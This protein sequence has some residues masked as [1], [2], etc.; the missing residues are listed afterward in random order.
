MR[1]RARVHRAWRIAH[2]SASEFPVGPRRLPKGTRS[3][4]IASARDG[5]L[6]AWTIRR[7]PPPMEF[8]SKLLAPAVLVAGALAALFAA[9][10]RSRHRPGIVLAGGALLAYLVLATP[11]GSS[12]LVAPLED[13]V[14]PARDC[15]PLRPDAIVVVLAG[16]MGG[17]A[18]RGLDTT[19]L[20][21]ASLRRT[22]AAARLAHEAPGLAFVL[23]GGIAVA[24][25]RAAAGDVRESDLMRA[26]MVELGVQPE[27]LVLERE[28]RNTWEN[29]TGS[30][31]LL[32]RGPWQGR[33]TY[34]VTSA[35]HMPRAA[36]TFRKAGID[37]CPLPAD[38]RAEPLVYPLALTPQPGA[39]ENSFA[40][41]HEIVGLL[42][43]A[44]AGR[45]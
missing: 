27:R 35:L 45:L 41:L 28:S 32:A 29:A 33:R 1:T 19:R 23:S 4:F 3:A 14:T 42:G 40:A 15:D 6:G 36:A 25:G 44:F 10:L 39:L 37:V 12:L 7:D 9:T 8:L 11:L 38:R 5:S 17:E 34:L 22:L 20:S 16:G 18:A 24:P 26:L 21:A 13:H 2:G 31:K 43:Y 30:A